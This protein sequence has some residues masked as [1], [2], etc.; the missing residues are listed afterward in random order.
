MLNNHRQ[1]SLGRVHLEFLTKKNLNVNYKLIIQLLLLFIHC[2][3]S[4]PVGA[5][6]FADFSQ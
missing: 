1:A 6:M 2:W 5:K 3:F 4:L